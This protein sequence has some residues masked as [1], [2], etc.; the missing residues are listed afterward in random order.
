LSPHFV[1]KNIIKEAVPLSNSNR[2]F[3]GTWVP[4]SAAPSVWKTHFSGEL[5][6]ASITNKKD[7]YLSVRH[8]HPKLKEVDDT[9]NVIIT[10]PNVPTQYGIKQ[11]VY[12]EPNFNYVITGEFFSQT[13]D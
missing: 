1:G 12:L 9:D 7:Y 5:I 3:K 11:S 8:P 2:Y 13:P 4:E 6:S 10:I